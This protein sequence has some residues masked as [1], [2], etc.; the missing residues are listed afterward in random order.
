MKQDAE[1]EEWIAVRRIALA[2]RAPALV[3][4]APSPAR[5]LL[6][7]TVKPFASAHL[8]AQA[9]RAGSARAPAEG[10]GPA[11]PHGQGD[12]QLQ[13][14]LLRAS[15]S[16]NGRMVAVPGVKILHVVE[17]ESGKPLWTTDRYQDLIAWAPQWDA[18][19]LAQAATGAPYMLDTRSGR[20]DTHPS[21]EKRLT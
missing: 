9:Q 5:A 4:A 11:G 15:P 18:V 2:L 17:V 6:P 14:R 1:L 10:A 13:R 16:P 12:R 20:I 3:P 21:T 19:V 8:A 7:N